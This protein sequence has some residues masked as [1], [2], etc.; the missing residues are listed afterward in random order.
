MQL[1][2]GADFNSVLMGVVL[3]DNAPV[4]VNASMQPAHCANAV[5]GL[6]LVRFGRGGL[7]AVPPVNLPE[8]R[9]CNAVLRRMAS[10]HR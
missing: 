2:F 9:Q 4:K 7:P 8:A 1:Q 10:Q 3:Q 5:C 6:L